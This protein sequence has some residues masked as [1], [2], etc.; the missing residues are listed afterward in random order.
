MRPQYTSELFEGDSHLISLYIF[1]SCVLLGLALSFHSYLPDVHFGGGTL[2]R[3]KVF[4][5][6]SVGCDMNVW[7]R[8]H[9]TLVLYP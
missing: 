5:T 3:L 7:W 1:V 6:L 8:S 4:W 2:L 9:Q